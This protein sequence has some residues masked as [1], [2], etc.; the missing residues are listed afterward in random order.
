MIYANRYFRLLQV[1]IVIMCIS[2]ISS[3]LQALRLFSNIANTPATENRDAIPFF[4]NIVLIISIGVSVYFGRKYLYNFSYFNLLREIKDDENLVHN[5][6]FTYMAEDYEDV[7]EPYKLEIPNYILIGFSTVYF[8]VYVSYYI[9][10]IL[11]FFSLQDSLQSISDFYV[12]IQTVPFFNT[13]LLP[14][15]A[16]TFYSYTMYFQIKCYKKYYQ[17]LLS[18]SKEEVDLTDELHEN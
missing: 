10:P 16:M 15:L 7:P 5:S 13:S 18:D 17:I 6:K 2:G 8:L 1:S 14:V 9:R 11:S 4:L 12:Y 3:L